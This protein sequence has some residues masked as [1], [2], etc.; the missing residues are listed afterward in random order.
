M[1][2][3]DEDFEKFYIG[4]CLVDENPAKYICIACDIQFGGRRD[5]ELSL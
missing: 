5:T 4:G 1:P 2:S 3:G